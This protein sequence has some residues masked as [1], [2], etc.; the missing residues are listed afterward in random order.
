MNDVR[1]NELKPG[2]V[3]TVTVDGN[4]VT[5]TFL[6]YVMIGSETALVLNDEK[7]KVYVPSPS[8]TLMRLVKQAPEEGPESPKD[9]YYG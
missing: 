1:R 5:G 3:Y 2:S 4:E 8:I 6:G 7:G 9:I